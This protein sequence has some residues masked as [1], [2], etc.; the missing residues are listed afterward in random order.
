MDDLFK[1]LIY[2]FLFSSI[3]MQFSYNISLNLCQ[4]LL[5]NYTKLNKY[6]DPKDYEGKIVF[7]SSN[8]PVYHSLHNKQFNLSFKAACS[9]QIISHCLPSYNR[10]IGI[11]YEWSSFNSF[12]NI[13]YAPFDIGNFTID[14]KSFSNQQLEFQTFIPSDEEIIKFEK[15]AAAKKYYYLKNGYFF[16]KSFPSTNLKHKLYDCT[17][18]D[19]M[20]EF[21]IFNSDSISVL[22]VVDK[23]IIKYFNYYSI[24]FSGIFE[25]KILLNE[26]VDNFLLSKKKQAH[27]LFLERGL[28]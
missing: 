27:L 9:K 22:G 3:L 12:T 11:E 28:H 23:G 14:T 21:K 17:P 20:I 13:S 18:N 16:D 19:K 2:V 26:L 7:I 1:I 5:K 4:C 24:D 25:R 6:S 15:S 10:N 8:K